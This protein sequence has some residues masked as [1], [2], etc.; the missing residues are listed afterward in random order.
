[1]KMCS[2]IVMTFAVMAAL[3]AISPA[4]SFAQKF[5]HPGINQT[6]NDLEY[7]KKR[8]LKGEQPYKDAFDRLKASADTAFAVKA[9]TH[10]LRGPYGRPNVGG[11][12][13]SKSANMPYNYALMWYITNDKTYAN[14]AIEI[15]NALVTLIVG[16]RLQRRQIACRVDWPFIL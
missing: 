1:M 7:M 8:V 15:L 12:D 3:A 9:H 11:D 16:L 10:V 6:S 13:L 2:R 4:R 5:I 14:K